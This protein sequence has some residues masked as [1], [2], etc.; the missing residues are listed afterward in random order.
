MVDAAD[1]LPNPIR[2]GVGHS[3]RAARLRAGLS[4]R[5]FAARCGVSQPFVS[6]VE[7]GLST[8]S[9]ATLYAMATVLDIE[10]SELLPRR[11]T[12][13]IDVIRAGDGERVPSSDRPGSAVGRVL[14][15]DSDRHLEI[16]E[17]V[18]D[19]SEDLDVWYE[20]PGEVVLH[21]IDGN[22]HVE[23]SGHPDVELG[24]GDCLVHPG[25]LAHRWTVIGTERVRLFLVIVRSDSAGS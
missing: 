4:M 22:L 2:V 23:L 12:D 25:R 16:Y 9:I 18:T 7:R 20:H 14:L 11:H 17:Y 5:D 24:P 6:A 19:A 15:T 10:P 1:A 3:I 13:G 8:P 21:L